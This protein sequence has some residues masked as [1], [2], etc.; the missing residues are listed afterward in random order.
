MNSIH[1]DKDDMNYFGNH[2][3]LFKYGVSKDQMVSYHKFLEGRLPL[4]MEKYTCPHS[5][6]L[7]EWS[8]G[9]CIS[10][11]EYKKC[12]KFGTGECWK[13]FYGDAKTAGE[14]QDVLKK[15]KLS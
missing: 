5:V 10:Y 13:M 3:E 12:S 4:P 7:G 11:I 9:D 6:T 1:F 8:L 2:K 15:L 14:K